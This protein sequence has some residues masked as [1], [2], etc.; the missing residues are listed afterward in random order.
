MAAL[1]EVCVDNVASALA[2]QRAG[3]ARV[4]LC[5]ALAL[6]GTTPSIGMVRVVLRRLAE[7]AAAQG[8]AAPPPPPIPVHALVRPRAGDFCYSADEAEVMVADVAA[9]RRLEEG[10]RRV[11]GVVLGALE[12]DGAV[13]VALMRRLIEAARGG[14]GGGGGAAAAAAAEGADAVAGPP[15]SVTFHRAIDASRDPLEALRA[16]LALRV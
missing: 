9:L 14:G 13:D 12:P 1:L 5:D 7:D 3:A 11:A 16:C 8:G 6:G 4:E 15:L 2:A 10:G